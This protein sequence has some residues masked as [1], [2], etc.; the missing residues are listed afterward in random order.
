[1]HMLQSLFDEADVDKSGDLTLDETAKVMRKFCVTHKVSRSAN[2]I[3]KELES[4]LKTY[5]NSKSELTGEPT[6]SFDD[7]AVMICSGGNP[8]D[9][10]VPIIRFPLP[11]APQIAQHASPASRNNP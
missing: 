4:C 1:M 11:E 8:A 10:D 5:S 7:F 2:A 9:R 3:K 6:L